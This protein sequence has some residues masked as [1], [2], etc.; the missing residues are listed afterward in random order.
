MDLEEIKNLLVHK[1]KEK[2]IDLI[3]LLLSKHSYPVFGAAKQIEQEIAAIEVLK[4]I[5]YLQQQ[6]D[7]YDYIHKLKITKAKARNLMYQE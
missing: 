2:L 7:E 6:S 3:L 5:A 4:Q 1:D